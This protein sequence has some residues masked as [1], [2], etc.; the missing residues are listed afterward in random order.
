MEKQALY[1]GVVILS[2]ISIV[3]FSNSIHTWWKNKSETKENITD[4]ILKELKEE[5]KKAREA[6]ERNT[7]QL[8][9]MNANF[10]HMT[11]KDNARDERMNSHSKKIDKNT[12]DIIGIKKDV[13]YIKDR[14]DKEKDTN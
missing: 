3:N 6:T 12:E 9:E 4:V 10:R 1:I 2:L 14:V 8:I 13:I 11:E 5:Q 7:E